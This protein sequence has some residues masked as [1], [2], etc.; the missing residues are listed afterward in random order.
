M[1][2]KHDIFD[3]NVC[4]LCLRVCIFNRPLQGINGHACATFHESRPTGS[5]SIMHAKKNR[6]DLDL[7]PM[8]LIFNRVLEVHGKKIHQAKCRGSWVIVLTEKKLSDNVEN[9]TAVVSAA[10]KIHNYT[11]YTERPFSASIHTDIMIMTCNSKTQTV[12]CS[13]LKMTLQ[14]CY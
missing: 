4:D 14:P 9:N 10:V 8:T 2:D 7:C 12:Q 11:L 3:P 1:S 6:C 13:L 5:S